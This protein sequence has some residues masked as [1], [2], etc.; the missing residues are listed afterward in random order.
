ME[1]G[2]EVRGDHRHLRSPPRSAE[3][4]HHDTQDK[5]QEDIPM[6]MSFGLIEGGGAIVFG[7][8]DFTVTKGAGVFQLK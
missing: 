3:S 2:R 6:P 7:S 1:T 5:K 8:G 4:S